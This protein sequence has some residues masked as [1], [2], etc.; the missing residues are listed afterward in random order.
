MRV[1]KKAWPEF[2][3]AIQ[4]GKKKFDVRLAEFNC[5][6]GDWLLLKEWNPKNKK[7]TGRKLKRKIAFVFNTKKQKFWKKREIEKKGLQVIG[8]K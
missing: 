7:F 3:Q 8:W 5:K 2:F 1:T 6:P 4:S